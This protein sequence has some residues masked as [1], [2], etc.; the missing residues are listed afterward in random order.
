[1]NLLL[2]IILCAVAVVWNCAPGEETFDAGKRYNVVLIVS[3]ALRH[4]VL[5]CYGGGAVTPNI[6]WLAEN[7]VLFENAYANSSWTAPSSVSM[8]TGNYA[9]TYA[10]SPYARTIKIHVPDGEVLFAEVL[11]ESGYATVAVVEN[12]HA[13]WHNH[14]QGFGIVSQGKEPGSTATEETREA[15]AQIAGRELSRSPYRETGVVLRHVLEFPSDQNFLIHFWMLDPHEPYSPVGQFRKKVNENAPRLPRSRRFYEG[16][17]LPMNQ[18][19]EVEQ[20]HVKSLYLA[21]VESVDERVGFI[22][23]ALRRKNLL[24]N[25]YVILT[26]DHGE[27]FG[28]HGRWGHRACYYDALMRIPLIITGPNVP[29]GSRPTARVSLVDIMPTLKDLLGVEY[30]RNMQGESVRPAWDGGQRTKQSIYIASIKRPK[31]EDTKHVDALIENGYKLIS[32]GDNEFELYDLRNDPG[33]SENLAAEYRDLAQ[34]MFGKIERQRAE[35]EI[36]MM[37]NASDLADSA[38]ALTEEELREIK[39]KLKALGYLQ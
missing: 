11:Q 17:G 25:T 37:R 26:S 27:M 5:G 4:D 20:E 14:L 30:A 24:E 9:T 39:E 15:I 32:L 29:K 22:I 31:Q 16:A 38:T 35:N 7:G 33:E 1:M 18:L 3:D 28:E 6:D 36:R 23:E 10:H 34:S 21:E 12:I 13:Y 2:A 19:S 8:F